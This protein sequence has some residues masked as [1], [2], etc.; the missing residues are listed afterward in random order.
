M[1]TLIAIVF[2]MI[3]FSLN[4]SQANTFEALY[5]GN[6]HQVEY[7]H[8]LTAIGC[9]SVV[10]KIKACQGGCPT[11]FFPLPNG[12]YFASCAFR[13]GS[14]EFYKTYYLRCK[15][16]KIKAFK[17]KSYGDCSC[18][19]RKCYMKNFQHDT[20]VT[21]K[22]IDNLKRPCRNI[23][24]ICRRTKRQVS[25]LVEEKSQMEYLQMSCRTFDCKKRISLNKFENFTDKK[26]SMK[27]SCRKCKR[28]KMNKTKRRQK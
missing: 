24:R 21:P 1:N 16:G 17:I 25:A 7:N 19:K 18:S 3:S 20:A 22:K 15:F 2:C 9:E 26:E 5:Q 13:N 6:C 10:I 8:N 23:C 12:K 27:L 28:C 11:G 4:H 14:N